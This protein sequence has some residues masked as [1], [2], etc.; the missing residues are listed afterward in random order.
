[1]G[2]HSDCERGPKP[3]GGRE[4][5]TE[6]LARFNML[7]VVAVPGGG[8]AGRGATKR[9][10]QGQLNGVGVPSQF[11]AIP[12]SAAFCPRAQHRA[13]RAGPQAVTPGGHLHTSHPRLKGVFTPHTQLPLG[14][15][16]L[17]S[18]AARRNNHV[19][20]PGR[21]L[22][23]LAQPAAKDEVET[24]PGTHYHAANDSPGTSTKSRSVF[25]LVLLLRGCC[26]RSSALA[27]SP[28]MFAPR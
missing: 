3:E 26:V 1:M 14:C 2:R 15:D 17:G 10:T 28:L 27:R 12:L 18:C 6:V 20:R 8:V 13:P 24:R 23:G 21:E 9:H 4:G 25:H 19:R 11:A 16:C 5:A 7:V 22:R